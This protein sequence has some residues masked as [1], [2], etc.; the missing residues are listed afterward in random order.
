VLQRHLLPVFG[1]VPIVR[2]HRA[3]FKDFLATKL[4]GGTSREYVKLIL[5]VLHIVLEAAQ[6]DEVIVVNPAAKLRKPFKLSKKT[7]VLPDEIKAM[8]RPQVAAFLAA[9]DVLVPRLAALFLLLA[10]TGLRLGEAL[11]LHWTDLDFQGG[12]LRVARTLSTGKVGT[13]KSGAARDVDVSP[14][15][16]RRLR[17][18]H[19]ARKTEALGR[20]WSEMPPWIFCTRTGHPYHHRVIQRAFARVLTKASLPEHFTPHSLRHSFASI[21]ISEGESLAYVQR[22]LGHASIKLTVDL[23]GSWLPMTGRGADRLDEGGSGSKVVAPTGGGTQTS[24]FSGT[25]G[26]QPPKSFDDLEA[27]QDEPGAPKPTED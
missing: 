17:R 6:D 16:A 4:A 15:L 25:S 11:A 20:G 9:A 2:L 14:M 19:L 5:S 23:Y 27:D 13:P 18:L 22:M 26:N 10:R 24:M 3:Q 1:A 21:P 7:A 12:T 8:T